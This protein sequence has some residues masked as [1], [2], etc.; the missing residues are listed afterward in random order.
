MDTINRAIRF[1]YDPEP[2]NDEPTQSI[3]L[4]GAEYAGIPPPPPLQAAALAAVGAAPEREEKGLGWPEAFLDDYETRLWLTYRI[5]FPAISKK[6]VEEQVD[7]VNEAE[8]AAAASV[9]GTN[10]VT[11]WM[12]E[13]GDKFSRNANGAAQVYTSDVGWGCMIRSAQSLLANALLILHLGRD[14]RHNTTSAENEF[15]LIKLFADHPSAPFSLHRFVSHASTFCGKAPGEWFGPSAAAQC[16]KALCAEYAGSTELRAGEGGSR[17]GVYVAAD[18]GDIY[19]NRVREIACGTDGVW[20][21]ILI[22][23][24]VRLGIERVNPVYYPAIQDCLKSPHGIGVAGGRPSSSH[25]FIATQESFTHNPNLFYLDPH[26]PRPHL[27]LEPTT[28]DVESVHTRR[29]RRCRMDEVDPSMLVGYLIRDEP[30]WEA[31]KTSLQGKGK[32]VVHV[33]DREPELRRRASAVKVTTSTPIATPT[34]TESPGLGGEAEV[35]EE[36]EGEEEVDV[37][38]DAEGLQ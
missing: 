14:Y 20:K 15:E 38:S 18:G 36:E 29:V 23:A 11:S 25:Y 2:R 32:K 30:S 7:T 9:D 35:V 26:H 12:K 37:L 34:K 21:P 31:F 28:P 24:G 19:E 13:V 27:P 4:L 8:R 10:G 1:F 5:G 6:V 16:I 33:Y 17:V 3:W 22:L